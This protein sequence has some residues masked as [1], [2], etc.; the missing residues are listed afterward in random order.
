MIMWR[1]IVAYA[2]LWLPIVGAGILICWAVG[3][4]YGGNKVL[5][6]WLT[7]GGVVCLLFLAALQWQHAIEKAEGTKHPTDAE[8]ERDRARIF[9]GKAELRNLY[10]NS[11]PPEVYFEFQNLGQT[12]AIDVQVDLN[13]ATKPATDNSFQLSNTPNPSKGVIGPGMGF[14]GAVSLPVV[15]NDATRQGMKDGLVILYAWGE[16]VYFDKYAHR[17]TTKFRTFV[18]VNAVRDGL[19]SATPGGNEND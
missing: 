6:V 5:A 13:I 17:R 19:M 14:S 15:L 10:N 1:K 4:Y 16:V 3:A 7:F 9:I 12:Q 2:E 8:I 11:I 18:P